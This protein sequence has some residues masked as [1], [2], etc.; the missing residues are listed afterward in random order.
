MGWFT[1]KYP[2]SLNVGGLGWAHVVAGEVDLGRV[3]KDAKEQ[4]R[5][6]P[7]PLSYGILRYLNSDVELAGPDPPIGFSYIGRLGAQATDGDHWRLCQEGSTVHGAAKAIPMPLMHTVELNAAIVDSE[8]GPQLRADWT[9]AP[10]ALDG[11][12]VGRLSRLWFDALAGIC[13]HVRRGGGGLTPSDVA[14]AGLTQQ[15]LDELHQRYDIADVLPL[16]P[17]QQGL[18]FHANTAEGDDT[19]LYAVQLDFTVCGA[20]DPDRLRDAVHAVVRRYPNLAARFVDR[21]DEPVQIILADPV[22]GWQYR[23]SQRQPA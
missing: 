19:D 15:Q 11:A 7:D 20:I 5:G 1:T 9:W 18:L 14:P 10:S 17:L 23:R 2:V 16:T 3:L 8:I 6:L 4:L 21:F 13:A 12:A 22:A